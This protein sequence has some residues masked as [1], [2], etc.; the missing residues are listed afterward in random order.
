MGFIGIN[1]GMLSSYDNVE[2]SESL[3]GYDKITAMKNICWTV[4]RVVNLNKLNRT[5][6]LEPKYMK[7]DCCGSINTTENRPKFQDL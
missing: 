2:T 3:T 5:E 1:V 4:V 6:M 7:A